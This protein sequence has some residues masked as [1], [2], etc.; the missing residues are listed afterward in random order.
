MDDELCVIWE[1]IIDFSEDEDEG[2]G[3][4]FFIS[5]FEYELGLF[6]LFEVNG[7]LSYFFFIFVLDVEEVEMVEYLIGVFI[8]FDDLVCV[9]QIC[10]Y[11]E[12][13]FKLNFVVWVNV[14]EL[15]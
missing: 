13:S 14:F 11:V 6:N 10:I 7:G 8:V 3:L 15:W 12:E 4:F 5:D 9:Q 1:D 2:L